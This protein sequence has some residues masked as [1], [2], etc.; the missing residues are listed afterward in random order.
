LIRARS[1]ALA[2]LG[3][4][5]SIKSSFSSSENFK[6]LSINLHHL[7]ALSSLLCNIISLEKYA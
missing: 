4:L 7:Q 5:I 6:L 3:S 1:S 2:I